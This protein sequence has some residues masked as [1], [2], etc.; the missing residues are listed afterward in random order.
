MST[1]RRGRGEGGIHCD[2]QRQR[3]IA[4]VTTGYTP[5]G[6]RIVRR[7]SGKTETQARAKLK[8][9][10]RDHEDGLAIGPQNLTVAHIVKDWPEK[11]IL[12]VVGHGF[13]PLRRSRGFG[14][15]WARRG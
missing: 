2:E 1:R 9:V 10:L 14:R 5:A 12:A 4:S 3:F 6:K 11:K 8:E 7:G 15:G 13:S